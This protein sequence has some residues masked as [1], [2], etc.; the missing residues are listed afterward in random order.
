MPK[1]R[2]LIRR[3]Q[4]QNKADSDRLLE[5][6]RKSMECH[7]TAADS[8]SYH[9]AEE[10][11]TVDLKC[12]TSD[13]D[14]SDIETTELDKTPSSDDFE[15]ELSDC[16][17]G[18]PQVPIDINVMLKNWALSEK[19]ANHSVSKLLSIL[20]K[21][22]GLHSLPSDA[23]TLLKTPRSIE[24]YSCAGGKMN[25]FGIKNNLVASVAGNNKNLKMCDF[26][27]MQNLNTNPPLLSISVNMDGLPIS[28]SSRLSF[29]PILGMCDQLNNTHPF[30]IALY[31]GNSKPSVA[32][33][34]MENFVNEAKSLEQNGLVIDG[35]HY[36]FR[37]SSII[38][39]SPAKCLMKNT[40]Q[41]NSF[42]GCQICCQTGQWV[43]RTVWPYESNFQLRTDETFNDLGYE[44]HQLGRSLLSNLSLG[45]VTQVPLDY[46]HL[47]LLGVVKRIIS[48]WIGPKCP[49]QTRLGPQSRE[50][51]SQR[52]LSLNS[53]IP[54][55]SEFRRRPRPIADYK[56]WKATEFRTFLLYCGPVVLRN[57]LHSDLYIHFLTLSVAIYIGIDPSLAKDSQWVAYAN[58]LM[59]V[60]VK[61][62]EIL[63]GTQMMVYNIHNCLHLMRDVGNYG[64][65]DGFSAFPFEN[66]MQT[67]KSW[68]R[69]PNKHLEQVS[70]R[71]GELESQDAIVK[72]EKSEKYRSRR[73]KIYYLQSPSVA[74][75]AVITTNEPDNCFLLMGNIIIL[76][77]EIRRRSPNNYVLSY[78]E[79]TEK[80][81]FFTEPLPSSR[82]GIY[83]IN[84]SDFSHQRLS[85][86]NASHIVKKCLLLPL[87]RGP[88]VIDEYSYVCIPYAS[89]LSRSN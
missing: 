86:V 8:H 34:F 76:I 55:C 47:I 83:K 68:L 11:S 36:Q 1:E 81:D 45:L 77:K 74:G 14:L 50:L 52:L 88:N 42:K 66:Y 31:E 30:V 85:H 60:F 28:K 79:L 51:I 44:G 69:G 5:T 63:Y 16:S 35:S 41:Y 71:L 70:K 20:N 4:R 82:L 9:F 58:E 15:S 65:L 72:H 10:T 24:T 29:W 37:I 64:C 84:K 12:S 46:M 17:E 59:K 3:R 48:A 73:G 43:G 78:H 38:L 27:C 23:R 25:Y 67:I 18:N 22:P 19:I 39:D 7:Q 56:Y 89:M 33:D 6:V 32:N 80:C 61:Q 75:N 62:T 53:H 13:S 40:V 49:R 54:S 87:F 57:I 26:P 2:S 21:L